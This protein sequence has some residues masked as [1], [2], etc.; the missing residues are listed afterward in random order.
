METLLAIN[1]EIYLQG[2]KMDASEFVPI[3]DEISALINSITFREDADKFYAKYSIIKNKQKNLKILTS[4]RYRGNMA[5]LGRAVQEPGVLEA[6]YD[7]VFM[8]VRRLRR[9]YKSC[10]DAL[11]ENP[12]A[13]RKCELLHLGL[14]L[15]DEL[16]RILESR[17]LSIEDEELRQQRYNYDFRDIS[18]RLLFPYVD[19]YEKFYE[20][21]GE[22]LKAK[23]G[24]AQ[25]TRAY[26]KDRLNPAG[27]KPDNLAT[28]EYHF[29][30]N[31]LAE[32]AI[33]DAFFEFAFS[34]EN[35]GNEE[36]KRLKLLKSSD[37]AKEYLTILDN[38]LMRETRGVRFTID[39]PNN[40]VNLNTGDFEEAI[41]LWL[42]I[43]IMS[44]KDI[45]VCKMCGNVFEPTRPNNLYCAR[46]T[47]WQIN[48]FNRRVNRMHALIEEE[49]STI[50][51]NNQL[52]N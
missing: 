15:R 2:A 33:Q 14:K 34:K 16:P 32:K 18:K 51:S 42:M 4:S 26:H 24:S 31:P 48:Y 52:N 28:V 47:Q 43:E 7:S 41:Y 5:S 6:Y 20:R 1:A 21:Y 27:I 25:D 13:C 17:Y 38:Y 44:H 29:W 49:N 3:K 23:Y 11:H 39:T 50:D 37:L 22:E 8:L 40:V 10:R 46:H 45:A 36:Y 30:E 19:T 35:S 12:S 9:Q